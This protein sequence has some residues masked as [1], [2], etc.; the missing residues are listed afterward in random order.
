MIY[1]A[2]GS[3]VEQ[4]VNGYQNGGYWNSVWD[5]TNYPDGYYRVI[6]DFG[7]VECFQNIHKKPIP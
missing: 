5:A 4:L 3:L 1:D 6:A 7:D 2:A